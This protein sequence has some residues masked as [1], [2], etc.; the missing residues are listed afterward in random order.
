MTIREKLVKDVNSVP[1]AGAV[2]VFNI[3]CFAFFPKR[4]CFGTERVQIAKRNRELLE[5]FQKSR[6]MTFTF[7]E[8]MYM[9]AQLMERSFEITTEKNELIW[10]YT[11]D[12]VETSTIKKIYRYNKCFLIITENSHYMASDL[13]LTHDILERR[14]HMASELPEYYRK[15]IV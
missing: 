13:Y 10:F 14:K 6:K 15:Y 5:A 4:N 12:I 9:Q 11:G 3:G 7:D 1:Y 2:N 8:P